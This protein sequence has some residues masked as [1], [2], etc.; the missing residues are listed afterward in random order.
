MKRTLENAC[1]LAL[2]ALL[3][4]CDV[5]MM[6]YAKKDGVSS[7]VSLSAVPSPTFTPVPNPTN[8]PL[9]VSL[10]TKVEILVNGALPLGKCA[11]LSVVT[12]GPDGTQTN[13]ADDIQ[14]SL[15]GVTGGDLHARSDCGD[16]PT[17]PLAWTVPRGQHAVTFFY[18]T[19]DPNMKTMTASPNRGLSA[20]SRQL[21]PTRVPVS[22]A[23][24][25]T[26]STGTSTFPAGRCSQAFQVRA[27]DATG[28][29][30]A[31]SQLA[32]T[33]SGL[34][35]A[36]AYDD[37]GCTTALS[38]AI[39]GSSTKTFYLKDNTFV[40]SFTIVATG[41]PDTTLTGSLATSAVEA[42]TALAFID[43]PAGAYGLGACNPMTSADKPLRVQARNVKGLE[44]T[45]TQA[46]QVTLSASPSGTFY[47]ASDCKSG[48]VTQITIPAGQKVSAPLYYRPTNPTRSP[49]AFS[50]KGQSAGLSDATL[51]ANFRFVPTN[52]KITGIPSAVASVCT[53]PFTLTTV[54]FLGGDVAPINGQITAKISGTGGAKLF[55]DA[56]TCA[57]GTEIA[58][59]TLSIPKVMN[60]G[61]QE[62]VDFYLFDATQETLGLE[63]TDGLTTKQ[64]FQ[65][66]VTRKSLEFD[67]SYN[68]VVAES[69]YGYRLLSPVGGTVS[70]GRA[71]VLD[72]QFLVAAGVYT[73]AQGSDHMT[74]ARVDAAGKPDSNFAVIGITFVA[75][76]GASSAANA[77]AVQSTTAG[78]RYLLAGRTQPPGDTATRNFGLARFTTSGTLDTSP[79]DGVVFG[80]AATPGLAAVDFNGGQ[81][82]AYA[83]ATLA[84]GDILLAGTSTRNVL[85]PD[86]SVA[87]QPDGVTPI[88]TSDMAWARFDKGGKLLGQG[89]FPFTGVASD[90]R[91][92]LVTSADGT[93]KVYLAGKVRRAIT[94][95][96]NTIQGDSFAVACLRASDLT[97]CTNVPSR[98]YGVGRIVT[99]F[100]GLT[101]TSFRDSFATSLVLQGG[102]K[103]V[104]AGGTQAGQSPGNIALAR[105]VLTDGDIDAA[106]PT[107]PNPFNTNGKVAADLFSQA[108]ETANAVALDAS[109]GILVAGSSNTGSGSLGLVARFTADGELD[110]SQPAF[111]ATFRATSGVAS[112]AALLIDALGRL[113][114]VGDGG[115]QPSLATYRLLP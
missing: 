83:I 64:S 77:I 30:V 68:P 70:S 41:S 58:S 3:P 22:F 28:S 20:A 74:V 2:V 82:E 10:P 16:T 32:F 45:A 29:A 110:R 107:H 103:L 17:S 90:A 48:A 40:D 84:N 36:T 111:S 79:V 86:G 47:T 81:D 66:Q 39:A 69:H 57:A 31:T 1:A 91:A 34:G 109:G 12:E 35:S 50:L 93:E 9:T 65:V 97:A 5:G 113:L 99:D 15:S 18:K 87:M 23:V 21:A 61:P 101:V 33:L 8:T 63:V 25:D 24:V 85:N 95:G 44:T 38:P 106:G 46:I 4:G 54:D 67:P 108:A 100:G 37:A 13:A 51:A 62:H 27:L 92:M 60:S 56:G 43:G 19:A 49:T 94:D 71:A 42:A 112:G 89:T 75:S 26:T 98:G 11:S 59:S 76:F 6:G 88:T 102:T 78:N 52:T 114:V 73:D 53:G 105:Y 104:V 7:A 72:G 115:G 80:D 55:T 14:I 96:T